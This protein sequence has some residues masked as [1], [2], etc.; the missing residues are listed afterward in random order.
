MSELDGHEAG[1]IRPDPRVGWSKQ[2]N[3]FG[4]EHTDA[5]SQHQTRWNVPRPMRQLQRQPPVR[6][7]SGV[8]GDGDAVQAENAETHP[9]RKC[10][11]LMIGAEP[12]SRISAESNKGYKVARDTAQSEVKVQVRN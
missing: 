7:T 5:G 3:C 12:R 1:S 9:K 6:R 4:G 2:K 11:L 8:V 10:W